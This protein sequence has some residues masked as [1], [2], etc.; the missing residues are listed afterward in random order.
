MITIPKLYNEEIREPWKKISVGVLS[1]LI[2]GDKAMELHEINYELLRVVEN[3][4]EKNRPFINT[5]A[6]NDLAT[7]K[8]L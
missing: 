3:I 1:K 6:I 8:V 2:L 5:R 4:K 7:G